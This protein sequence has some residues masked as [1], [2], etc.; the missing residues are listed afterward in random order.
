MATLI[1]GKSFSLLPPMASSSSGWLPS[2]A[3][4]SASFLSSL[5]ESSNVSRPLLP[6]SGSSLPL[7]IGSGHAPWPPPGW[8]VSDGGPRLVTRAQTKW[9]QKRFGCVGVGM[10]WAPTH[11]L[12]ALD[13]AKLVKEGFAKLLEIN[14][15]QLYRLPDEQRERTWMLRPTTSFVVHACRMLRDGS[16]YLKD[17][18]RS[19]VNDIL[20]NW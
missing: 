18:K 3:S 17:G 14:F 4:A 6:F 12:V 13:V 9:Y 20:Q 10:F 5:S 2:P 8:D 19:L 15:L 7:P 1:D 16:A 11:Q